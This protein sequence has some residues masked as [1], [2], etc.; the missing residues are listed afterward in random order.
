ML[1]A[2]DGASLLQIVRRGDLALVVTDLWMPSLTGGDVL[3]VR[4]SE[5]DETPFLVITAAPAWITE[6][7]CGMDEVTVLRK[8]FTIE[9]LVSAVEGVLADDSLPT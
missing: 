7:V 8:P 5:G 4:R 6:Q 2:A 1:E 9:A 3:H